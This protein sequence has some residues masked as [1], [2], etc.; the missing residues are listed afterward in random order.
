LG[1]RAVLA[2][3][4]RESGV[5]QRLE[6]VFPEVLA[7]SIRRSVRAAIA[8]RSSLDTTLS[9]L[10]VG[11]E[12]RTSAQGPDRAICVIRAAM[13]GSAESPQADS[14]GRP[15]YDRRGFMRRFN[16]TLSRAAIE[17]RPAAVAL[18]HLDGVADIARTVDTKV[19][20]QVMSA[21]ILRLPGDA[22]LGQLSTDILA[23]AVESADR[24]V[25]ESCVAR[26]AA[27]LREPVIIG[28]A[29][30]HLTPYAGAAILGQD[31][32][33]PRSLLDKARTAAAEARR[34]DTTRTLFFSDTLKL[35]SLARLDVAREMRE[36]IED[37][38]IHLRYFGR[39]DLATGRLVALVGYLRW[40]H[41]LRGELSPADF[42]GVA[43]TT[44]LA[45]ALSRLALE[46]LKDD[47]AALAS[48]L[49][50][51]T[52]M[53]FSALRHH[54]LEDDFIEEV[55]RFLG[56]GALPAS[57]LELRIA[58]RAFAAL[59]P[60]AYRALGQLGVQIIVDQ[61]G[62]GFVSL[63]RLARAPI[64]GLQL[65]QAWVSALR[66]DPMA[67]RIC[68]ASIGAATALGLT[69]IA[70]GIDSAAHRT[71]LLELGCQQGSG[72]YYATSATEFDTSIMRS[73]S[74]IVA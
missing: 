62:R 42:L 70:T 26:I 54:M 28:D 5:G 36:A 59:S 21:A 68:R 60:S 18:I 58:E 40:T 71:T 4:P 44:G 72:D 37:R 13:A 38:A 12:M 51:D 2:L 32:M 55:A 61:V 33:S 57:R 63:D 3:V 39:H 49:G 34:N 56:Q 6:S 1:G 45:P 65:D 7:T 22:Y 9:V 31:G 46:T 47:Y 66:K 41:P 52:R 48:R 27:S 20:E 64:S 29:A 30:F 11:Y 74:Q 19:A 23:L 10:D 8:Q 17:E 14:S 73:S 24:D 15:S 50:P 43:E 67:L 53:S 16:D 25:I 35:R 69:S